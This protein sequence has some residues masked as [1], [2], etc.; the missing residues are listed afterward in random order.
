MPW[1]PGRVYVTS[2]CPT[3]NWRERE[4]HGTDL[5]SSTRSAKFFQAIIYFTTFNAIISEFGA[6]LAENNTAQEQPFSRV[7]V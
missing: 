2:F 5:A 4:K 7:V 3:R 1:H 6:S